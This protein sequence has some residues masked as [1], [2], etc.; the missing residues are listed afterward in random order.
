MAQI[1]PSIIAK[2]FETAKRQIAQLEGK[3][4]WAQ[5]DIMDGR[6]VLPTSWDVPEDLQN[7]DGAIKLEAH[8]MVAEP[9][10]TLGEWLNY[11]DRVFVHAEATEHLAEILEAIDGS[12]AKFGVA[13]KIDT[14]LDVLADF[15]GKIKHVQLMSIDSLGYY[16]AKFDERIYDRVRTVA[17]TYPEMEINVDG[18]ITLDNAPQL[19][20]AGADN[21]V[22]G[23]AIW[24]AP[25]LNT[26]L[27]QFNSLVDQ[28]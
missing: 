19:L 28:K 14:P 9:E 17:S 16:G 13:L 7:V 26:A 15:Q 25:D 12:P 10:E 22:I 20:A 11:V 8:L 1:I 2:N 24:Q 3:V 6:F 21:L 4:A 5:L 23:S 27:E 18:G